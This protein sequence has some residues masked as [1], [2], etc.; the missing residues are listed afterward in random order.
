MLQKQLAVNKGNTTTDKRRRKNNFSNNNFVTYAK[1]VS[2]MNFQ[3]MKIILRFE[4]TVIMQENLEVSHMVSVIK[5]AKHEKKI[6]W[7]F[8]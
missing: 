6:Y 2:V 1:K 5:D 3:L 4:I 8:K 7:Q